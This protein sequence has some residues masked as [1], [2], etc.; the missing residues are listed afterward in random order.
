MTTRPSSQALEITQSGEKLGRRRPTHGRVWDM[1]SGTETRKLAGHDNAVSSVAISPDS[2]SIVSGSYDKTV[3]C[4]LACQQCSFH[5]APHLTVVSSEPE[6]E[7]EE[8]DRSCIAGR[9]AH[10]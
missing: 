5:P 10:T 2:K 8:L 1:A 6:P 7:P 4:V 3:R 9:P